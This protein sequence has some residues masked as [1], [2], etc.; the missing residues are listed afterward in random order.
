MKILRHRNIMHDGSHPSQYLLRNLSARM[1]LLSL[2]EP[3]RFLLGVL[4]EEVEVETEEEVEKDEEVEGSLEG[5]KGRRAGRE[6]EA[7]ARSVPGRDL[8]WV[9]GGH[10]NSYG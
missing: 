3:K 6:I 8:G 10:G 2:P 4:T 7:V 1:R 9:L 5:R